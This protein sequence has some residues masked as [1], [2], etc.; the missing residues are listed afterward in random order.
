MPLSQ[1]IDTVIAKLRT[2]LIDPDVA[3]KAVEQL[4]SAHVRKPPAQLDASI[5]SVVDRMRFSAVDY[6]AIEA[7]IAAWICL[8]GEI[9]EPAV[10]WV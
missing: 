6:L 3:A 5:R 2:N 7:E 4:I 8:R 9:E 1:E 10:L